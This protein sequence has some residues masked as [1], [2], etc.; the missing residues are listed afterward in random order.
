V[1]VYLTVQM[2]L[3]KVVVRLD[4]PL[5][6]SS[7]QRESAFWKVKN[8]TGDTIAS[9]E[10]MREVVPVLPKPLALPKNSSVGAVNVSA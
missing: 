7:V 10:V 1:T 6:N 2:G 8:A 4:V 3:T 9:M 5:M